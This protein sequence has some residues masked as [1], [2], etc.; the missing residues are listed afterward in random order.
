MTAAFGEANFGVGSVATARLLLSCGANVHARCQFETVALHVSAAYSTTTELAA[1][2]LDNGSEVD[3]RDAEGETPL[4][5]AALSGRFAMAMLLV[6]H[7]AD[8][9]ARS[10]AGD[11]PEDLAAHEGGEAH[12][13]VAEY[14]ASLRVEYAR[15]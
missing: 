4:H 6:E 5:K 10:I 3:P 7:G 13:R 1:L 14:L 9:G 15:G 2:L 11:T 8:H 12:A